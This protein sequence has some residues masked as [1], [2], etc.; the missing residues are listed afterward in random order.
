MIGSMPLASWP[1]DQSANQAARRR[2]CTALDNWSDHQGPSQ[3]KPA[4]EHGP[5]AG[6]SAINAD[7]PYF[8]RLALGSLPVY[9]SSCFHFHSFTPSSAIRFQDDLLPHCGPNLSSNTLGCFPLI[10]CR[11]CRIQEKVVAVKFLFQGLS[12][13]YII[14]ITM[15]AQKHEL[16][17][18]WNKQCCCLY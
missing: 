11:K 3:P 18:T 7:I 12:R 9:R 13:P 2:F 6:G 10:S 17:L 1:T 15:T 5:A 16:S 8:W 4:A 14:G